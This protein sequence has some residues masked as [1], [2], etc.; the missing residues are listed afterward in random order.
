AR[1]SKS[2][3]GDAFLPTRRPIE[4]TDARALVTLEVLHLALVLLGGGSR[5]ERPE[6]APLAAL[7]IGFPRVEAVLA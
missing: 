6:I 1:W 4:S 3:L 7:G 2:D 5:F